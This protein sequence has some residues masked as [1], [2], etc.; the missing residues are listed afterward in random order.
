M[1]LTQRR[2][3]LEKRIKQMSLEVSATQL[4]QLVD[5]LGLLEKWN[6]A[7]NL[8]AIRNPE[9]MI[10]RHLVDSLSVLNIVQGPRIIDVGSGPGLPGIPLAICRPD[11]SVTTLDSNGKKTRFQNQ[12]K[13]ALGLDNLTIING[14]AEQ[15][16]AEPFNEVISR[17]FA[18]LSDMIT[19][20][21]QLCAT[22]GVFLAMKGQYPA[23]EIAAMPE[24]IRLK[25]TH[26]LTVPGTD[27]ERH[28][29]VLEHVP[30]RG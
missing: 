15:C 8:T 3:L 2:A 11:L 27:G 16:E 25:T 18:S 5:Y 21:R 22:D 14:R 17:A 29:I 9:E 6:K 23:E 1:E 12:V 26:P 24:G 10:D 4:D 19:W 28:L 13:L 7:F 30:E 20:T